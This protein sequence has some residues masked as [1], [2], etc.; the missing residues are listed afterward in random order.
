VLHGT[1]NLG[2]ITIVFDT[3]YYTTEITK[4]VI[5]K[6]L[7]DMR[8]RNT[9]FGVLILSESALTKYL[10]KFLKREECKKLSFLILKQGVPSGIHKNDEDLFI[11]GYLTE[12]NRVSIKTRI[13][14]LVV[15][16]KN[17]KKKAFD[18]KI[19]PTKDDH[20]FSQ[21]STRTASP[22]LSSASN[23]RSSSNHA[24]RNFT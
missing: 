10:E 16:D 7:D 13:S 5:L 12:E 15:Y 14:E 19:Y 17:S 4:K 11:T 24:T 21:A 22:S 9:H 3:K 18:N 23:S 1:H 2:E 20:S 8:L 6:I